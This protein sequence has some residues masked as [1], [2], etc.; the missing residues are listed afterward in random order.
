MKNNENEIYEQNQGS[1]PT[2]QVRMHC[3]TTDLARRMP[4]FA[5]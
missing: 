1:F 4:H 2:I 3:K 5:T